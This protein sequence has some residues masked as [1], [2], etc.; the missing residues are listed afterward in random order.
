MNSIKFI[1]IVLLITITGCAGKY[2]L[3][4][5]TREIEL[6]IVDDESG[7]PLPKIMIYY[8]VEKGEVVR[9]VDT[10]FFRVVEEQYLTDQDGRCSIP[11]KWYIKYPFG[12]Q[13]ISSDQVAINIDVDDEIKKN[14]V[15]DAA[16]FWSRFNI[17]EDVNVEYFYNKNTKYKGYVIFSLESFMEKYHNSE[18]TIK[19]KNHDLLYN[20]NLTGNKKNR[21]VI[22][23]IKK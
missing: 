10:T 11:K 18:K 23:L 8:T 22:R 4:Q 19:L 9:F 12:L 20:F 15:N 3:F 16:A 2:G 6:I 5:S 21:F 1:I 7:K 13:W 17:Y 14:Y